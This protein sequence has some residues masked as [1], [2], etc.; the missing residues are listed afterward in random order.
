MKKSITTL[1]VVI[2]MVCFAFLMFAGCDNDFHYGRN[3]G[4]RKIR[5]RRPVYEVHRTQYKPVRRQRDD[6]K[7]EIKRGKERRERKN[8]EKR[9]REKEQKVRKSDR[10]RQEK[11]QK[12]VKRERRRDTERTKKTPRKERGQ[13]GERGKNRKRR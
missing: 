5:T 9:G 6:K 2:L 1:G 4:R 12:E 10:S 11:R 13:R 7:Y 3:Y 8:Y